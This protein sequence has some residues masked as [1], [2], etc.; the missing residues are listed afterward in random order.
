MVNRP[1]IWSTDQKYGQQTKNMVNI[2]EILSPYWTGPTGLTELAGLTGL[3]W[4]TGQTGLTGQIYGKS[5][6]MNH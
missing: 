4:L 6:V 5:E 1:E 3:V 2:P